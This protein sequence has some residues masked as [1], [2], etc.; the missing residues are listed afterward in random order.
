MVTQVTKT[1]DDLVNECRLTVNDQQ[2]PYRYADSTVI[3][4]INTAL[5]EVYRYRPD[6]YIGNFTT[7]VLSANL[8]N[9]YAKTD[10]QN[11]DGAAN[12]TPPVPVTPFPLDDRL[13][14][15]PI[16]FYVI[17][18]LELGDDEFADNNR[19]MT[20]LTAFRGMLISEGG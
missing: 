3:L 12:P 19:A 5:R 18:L 16:V 6:A 9:T 8:A 7:G 4:K 17:G 13:F 2:Y 1:L 14:F 15:G 10:L 11:Y 20:L